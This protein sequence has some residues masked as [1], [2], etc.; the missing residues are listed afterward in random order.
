[1]IMFST[2]AQLHPKNVCT[3]C[4]PI[5]PQKIQFSPSIL[6]DTSALFDID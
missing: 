2:S 3:F 1:M 5:P 6:E 4:F